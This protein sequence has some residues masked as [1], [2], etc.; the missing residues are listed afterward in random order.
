MQCNQK[1]PNVG[2]FFLHHV[3]QFNP[4]PFE[5]QR[6]HF[7]TVDNRAGEINCFR[8]NTELVKSSKEPSKPN[9][10]QWI[11]HKRSGRV[12]QYFVLDVITTTKRIDV[13]VGNRIVCNAVDCQVT[14]SEV[15]FQS[16]LRTEFASEPLVTFTNFGFNTSKSV[17]IARDWM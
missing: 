11:F 14:S 10:T 9:D 13:F 5:R 7:T 8:R 16:D 12:A 4:V 15:F 2:V 1:P 3:V 17:L 6:V